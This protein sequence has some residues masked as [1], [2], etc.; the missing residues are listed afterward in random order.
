MRNLFISTGVLI[1]SIIDFFYPPFR[2][3]ISLNMFRYGITGLINVA[4][5]QVLFFLVLHYIIGKKCLYL[6]FY[7]LSPHIGTLVLI[8]PVVIF[9][10]FLLQKY[11]T[12]T[13][14]ILR[15]RIQLIRYIFIV[16]FNL[17]VNALVLKLMVDGFNFW[18]SPSQLFANLLTIL[19]S[20]FFQK[21]FTFQHRSS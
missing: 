1:R 16:F 9:S 15:G 2:K 13:S 7:T 5:S 10:G 18:T 4:F 17:G 14:S 20:Y 8:F 19:I 6:G 11:V 3:Y 12:F 21:K